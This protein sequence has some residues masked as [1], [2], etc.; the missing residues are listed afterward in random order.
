MSVVNSGHLHV[1]SVL[2][3]V[4]LK[5]AL[6]LGHAVFYRSSFSQVRVLAEY[7]P[8]ILSLIQSIMYHCD[9]TFGS[10]LYARCVFSQPRVSREH[11]GARWGHRCYTE[12]S[13]LHLPTH[14]GSN[15]RCYI[16]PLNAFSSFRPFP[17][18]YI[19]TNFWESLSIKPRKPPWFDVSVAALCFCFVCFIIQYTTACLYS[20]WKWWTQWRIRSVTTTMMKEPYWAW[21][22]QNTAR[23]RNAGKTLSLGGLLESWVRFCGSK[24]LGVLA[25]DQQ[26]ASIHIFFIILLWC[27]KKIK[28]GWS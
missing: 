20:R 10:T 22:K 21:S 8:A 17:S 27:R 3:F 4:D 19:S 6:N 9:W 1:D 13:Q 2:I 23:K 12:P 14:T 18:Y 11:G 24:Q 26:S 5:K 7:S 28:C 25:W 15:F 16:F